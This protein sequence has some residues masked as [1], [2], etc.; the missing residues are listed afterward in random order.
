[1]PIQDGKMGWNPVRL[2]PMI[3][4]AAILAGDLGINMVQW[5]HMAAF[6]TVQMIATYACL[7][8]V[9]TVFYKRGNSISRLLSAY[10]IWLLFTRILLGD[11]TVSLRGELCCAAG[12]CAACKIS[13]SLD[14][15]GQRR[16]LNCYTAVVVG[17]LS[18]W[19][20]CGLLVVSADIGEI[21][22]FDMTIHLRD[23]L[24]K[25]GILR[26]LEFFTVHRNE[27]AAWFMIGLWLTA[28]QWTQHKEL[29]WRILLTCVGI[30]MYLMIALQHC[31]SVYVVTSIGFGMLAV[32]LLKDR[33][34]N[35][36]RYIPISVIVIAAMFSMLFVYKE[37]SACNRMIVKYSS[38]RVQSNAQLSAGEPV[39]EQQNLPEQ[40]AALP[41]AEDTA[42]VG[43]VETADAALPEN[44]AAKA[45]APEQNAQLMDNRS[46]FRD[47]LTLTMRTEVW[48]AVCNTLRTHAEFLPLGQ[49]ENEIALNL[50]RYGGMTRPISHTHSAFAQVL[51]L[52][53]IPGFL[54]LL[55]IVILLAGRMVHCFFSKANLC[56]KVLTIPLR[57]LLIYSVMEPMFS[58][59]LE[60]SSV[61]FMLLA[62]MVSSADS[63]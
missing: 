2:I 16:L 51:S 20:V 55:V 23:E 33:L 34:R 26:F 59:H 13:S 6:R 43:V 41:E 14:A 38:F 27:S 49:P 45:A 58:S 18:V 46:F 29:R 52:C 22:L 10:F 17:I 5:E 50:H 35:R 56:K 40:N 42:E 53:G 21:A 30:L 61:C 1:M 57:C 12:M 25:T 3:F 11:L 31:R 39:Q 8:C 24:Q 37:F 54:L 19:A 9:S 62:G 7:L 47:L 60:F 44:G 28:A 36:K 63:P 48:S 32:L 4:C 15:N